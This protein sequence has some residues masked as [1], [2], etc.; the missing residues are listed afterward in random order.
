MG[1]ALPVVVLG[2]SAAGSRHFFGKLE[3][4]A[5]GAHGEGRTPWRAARRPQSHEDP[6]S[7]PQRS[8]GAAV[9]VM[10]RDEA[11]RR[12]AVNMTCIE[13]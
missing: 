12:R 1:S 2:C 10:C 8:P 5:A 13:V 3:A 9:L 11:A 6:L 4:R 7:G